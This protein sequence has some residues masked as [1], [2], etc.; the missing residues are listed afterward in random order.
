MEMFNH[1][2]NNESV[3]NVSVKEE[4]VANEDEIDFPNDP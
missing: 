2:T 4:N 1:F 3:N